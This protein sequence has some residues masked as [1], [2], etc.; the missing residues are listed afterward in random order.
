MYSKDKYS[1]GNI[2]CKDKKKLLGNYSVTTIFA[3]RHGLDEG[4]SKTLK[5]KWQGRL[6]GSVV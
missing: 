6:G 3:G 4:R 5:R 1:S 2:Y